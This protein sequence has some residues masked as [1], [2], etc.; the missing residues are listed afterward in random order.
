MP[1]LLIPMLRHSLLIPPTHLTNPLIQAM[2]NAHQQYLPDM[3]KFP[4]LIININNTTPFHLIA[5]QSLKLIQL[6]RLSSKMQSMN[7]SH[8]LRCQSSSPRPHMHR[9]SPLPSRPPSPLLRLRKL[10]MLLHFISKIRTR[11]RQM[12]KSHPMTPRRQRR[13]I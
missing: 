5:T 1:R 3:A 11:G 4:P 2:T 10:I 12:D 9:L 7:Q 13:A 8:R 6:P